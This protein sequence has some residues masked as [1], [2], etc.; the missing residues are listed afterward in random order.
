M[1]NSAMPVDPQK[2]SLSEFQK[3]FY[4]LVTAPEGVAQGLRDQGRA[5][6]DLNAWIREHGSLSPLERLDIYANMY[7]FRIRDILREEYSKV[8]A[9]IGDGDFH[10]LIVDYL[11]ARP[12]SHPS[13]RNAGQALPS[14]L[15]V[16]ELAGERPWLAE[17]AA[18]ERARI[19]VFDAAEVDTLTVDHLRTLTP[20]DFAG[21]ALRLIPAQIVLDAQFAVE[22]LWQWLDEG[23]AAME[24]EQAPRQVLVWRQDVLVYHRALD[25][26]EAQL[27]PLLREGVPF[28]LICERLAEQDEPEAAAQRA[29]GLLGRW[30]SDGLLI[31]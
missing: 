18:L 12:P 31:G 9:S 19:E 21:L 3:S 20:D 11:V 17:L 25:A 14:Y 26:D 22:E 6:Q 24:P 2:L 30:A 10:N 7:F 1:T 23:G 29:F 28:G 27:L 5:L 16:H 15:T 4:A 8:V 13:V